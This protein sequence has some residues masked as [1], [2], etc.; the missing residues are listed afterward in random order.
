MIYQSGYQR[1]KMKRLELWNRGGYRHGINNGILAAFR[2][3]DG[4]ASEGSK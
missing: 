4:N 3:P 2:T 1:G